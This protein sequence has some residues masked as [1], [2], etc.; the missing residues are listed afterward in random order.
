MKRIAYHKLVR[1]KIPQIVETSGRKPVVQII[2]PAKKLHFLEE[3]LKEE[4]A[5]YL[6]SH[7]SEELADILEVMHGIADCMGTSWEELEQIRVQKKQERG[8]FDDG[9]LLMEIIEP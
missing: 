5:E 2:E 7:A 8:G 6:E 4:L 3:K 1:D 9:I